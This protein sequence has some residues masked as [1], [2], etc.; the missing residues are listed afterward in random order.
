MARGI[1]LI[2]AAVLI[3]VVL[4]NATDGPEPFPADGSSATA[5]DDDTTTTTEPDDQTT[6][7]VP[8]AAAHN[9]AEVTVL[10]ANGTGGQISGLA[11]RIA[12]QLRPQNY[13][14]AEPGNTEAAA[15]ESAVFYAEGYEAD[16]AA[17]AALL[18]PPP[19][20]AP[21]PTPPP[22]ADMKGAHILVV[23]AADLA[24]AQG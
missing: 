4:L 14:L 10:V 13:V 5:D 23:A 21:L 20:T 1:A 9:P 16:A 12:D 3:G 6:S 18:S 19:T 24:A 8:T 11:G 7:S 15:D 17:I 2:V 22:V